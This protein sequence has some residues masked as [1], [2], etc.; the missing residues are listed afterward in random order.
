MAYYTEKNNYFY[1]YDKDPI[2]QKYRCMKPLG[3]IT[4]TQ[5]KKEVTLWEADHIRGKGVIAAK[6]RTMQSLFDEYLQFLVVNE[7]S[8]DTIRDIKQ[9]MPDF[10]KTM[11]WLKD[12]T[13]EHIK[14]WDYILQNWTCK[15]WNRGKPL[16]KESRAH[17]LRVLSAFCGWLVKQEYLSETP[18]KIKIPA[19]RKDAGR[20]LSGDQVK[21]LFD[22]WPAGKIGSPFEYS[23]LAKLFYLI[24]FY[25]GTRSKELL[26]FYDDHT[27]TEHHGITYECL[28]RA[29]GFFTLGKTKDGKP[30]EV[31][32]AKEV[33]DLIPAGTGPMF[34]GKISAHC[35]AQYL[36]RACQAAGITGRFRPHDSRVTAASDWGRRGKNP[37]SLMDQFG[38][39]T[40]AMALHYTK[41][42]TKDRVEDAQGM[43]K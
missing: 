11:T 20:A 39:S 22:N 12:L 16:S 34:Y 36:K 15:S 31:G 30:R 2:T 40:E 18:F 17:R 37:K 35:L 38:W 7:Y 8:V 28:N 27:E 26:G 14:G 19:Q 9:C 42:A 10:I 33:M 29:Q 21:R 32:L 6:N 5:A 23:Y 3:Q 24:K 1:L 41:V 25:A 13:S 4:E 43:Y